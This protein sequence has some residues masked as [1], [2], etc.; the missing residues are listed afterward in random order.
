[1]NSV[2]HVG[3]RNFD[4]RNMKMTEALSSQL[5]K[6]GYKGRMVSIQ[7]LDDLKEE[8][9]DY[10]SHGSFDEEFYKER[11]SRFT[12][13]VPDSLP[14]ARSLIVIAVPRPQIR[15]VFNWKG[16]KLSLIIPPTY[17]DNEEIDRQ[18]E[19]LLRGVLSPKKYRV[20]KA[21]LPEKL[22]AVRSGLGFYGRN[23]IC[24]V[25]GMGSF[26]QLVVFYTELPCEEDN[27]QESQL[28]ESCEGCS[29]C[30]DNCPTGAITPERF[31][32]R[33]ER[34][35]TFHNERR[36]DFPTWIDPS[37]HKCIVGCLDCQ[38]ICPENKNI[39]EWIEEKGEFSQEE[40]ALLLEGKMLNRLSSTLII[41]LKQLDLMEYLDVLPRN[42]SVLLD[43][44]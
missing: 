5:K 4:E 29:A 22:L 8:I 38:T 7:H 44:E 18:V 27:W 17:V 13:G 25:N 21:L 12:F 26:H 20:A 16:E 10:H 36:E 35:I 1:M 41:K 32:L 19:N 39:L 40:T 24:Y 28:M 3:E 2:S 33:A 11:L 6:L 9:G 23:N 37:W 31:L 14:Q 34:C 43:K 15:V 30:L 42:L